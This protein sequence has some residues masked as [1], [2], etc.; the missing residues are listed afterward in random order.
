MPLDS[1]LCHAA[2]ISNASDAKVSLAFFLAT[3]LPSRAGAI[4][5][6]VSLSTKNAAYWGLRTQ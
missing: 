2:I 3:N 4:G 1:R 6:A 5:T